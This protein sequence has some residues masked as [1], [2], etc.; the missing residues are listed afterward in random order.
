MTPDRPRPTIRLTEAE[1]QHAAAR[2][3]TAHDEQRI[4]LDELD[5]RLAAVYR[6]EVAG[7][8]EPPLADIPT[9]RERRMLSDR[10]D[11]VHEIRPGR[12]GLDRRGRWPVPRRL[13]I[14]TSGVPTNASTCL[15]DFRTAVVAIRGWTSISSVSVRCS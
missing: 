2:L 12:Q 10:N 1:R 3:F 14:D 6:A 5:E 15:L 11:E 13:R 4:S 7:E 8:L 9:D